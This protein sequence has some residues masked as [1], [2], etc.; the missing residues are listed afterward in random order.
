MRKRVSN[1]RAFEG[2]EQHRARGAKIVFTNGCFDLLHVGHVRYLAEA[3]GLGDVLVVGLNSD[4]SVTALKG[5]Q[6]PITPESQRREVLLA[7]RSVDYVCTFDEATPLEL[8]KEVRPHILVKGGDWP[9][10]KIVG[11]DFVLSY[12][13]E[14]HSLSYHAGH[15]TTDI[16]KKIITLG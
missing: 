16:L 14:V 1:E 6:R 12:G 11:A 5:P 4:S 13:G 3:K 9:L 15:S 2:L 8:I 10:E 7:L